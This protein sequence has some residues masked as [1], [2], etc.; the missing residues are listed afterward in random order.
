MP[1]ANETEEDELMHRNNSNPNKYCL[2]C[3]LEFCH[4]TRH[5][6]ANHPRDYKN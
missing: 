3:D 6:M 2:K 1:T 5:N 4:D